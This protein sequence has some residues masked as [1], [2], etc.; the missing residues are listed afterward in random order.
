MYYVYGIYIYGKYVYGIYIYIY[1]NYIYGNYIYYI[2]EHNAELNSL[3]SR[4]LG[5]A[6]VPL[7]WDSRE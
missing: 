6:K 1:G 3:I 5:I 4:N 7:I 2:K